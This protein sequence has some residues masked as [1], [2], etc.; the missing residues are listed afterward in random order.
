[1][2]FQIQDAFATEP[3]IPAVDEIVIP[4]ETEAVEDK[5]EDNLI[6]QSKD[7]KF[8]EPPTAST[9][10]VAEVGLQF[11][12]L[13]PTFM[14]Y[15]DQMKPFSMKIPKLWVLNLQRIMYRV[16]VVRAYIE[17]KNNKLVL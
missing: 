8:S 13:L 15:G 17:F 14:D 4:S 16:S 10:A 1:M 11:F 6:E 2:P 7:I 3:L 9:S 12:L 5:I